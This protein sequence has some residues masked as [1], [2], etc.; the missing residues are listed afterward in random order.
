MKKKT[1]I[2]A[3][4]LILAIAFSGCGNS[5]ETVYEE[6][7]RTDETQSADD[8]A[9]NASGADE[10]KSEEEKSSEEKTGEDS[11]FGGSG[12]EEDAD[13]LRLIN[14]YFDMSK[15]TDGEGYVY[16][17]CF[18]NHILCTPESGSSHPELAKTLK[19]I[20]DDE[21]A[22]FADEISKYERDAFEY[23]E[24]ARAAGADGYYYSYA[25]DVLKRADDKCVSIVRVMKGY[26][27]GAHPDYYYETYNVDPST[28]KDIIMSDVITDQEKLNKIL[29]QKL[30]ADYPDVEY[31]GL[32]DSLAE[33]DI[34]LKE[35]SEDPDGNYHYAY[36]FTLDPD[37]VSFYFSPYGISAYA[38]G[39]QVVK[40]LYD[41]EPSLFK[42]DYSHS[43]GYISYLTEAENKY[44]FGGTAEELK[45]SREE[46]DQNDYFSK[47]NIYKGSKELSLGDMDYYSLKAFTAHTDDD[48]DYLYIIA[49]M[50][51]DYKDFY[52]VDLSKD[53]P[54]EVK[55]DGSL[56]Y[57]YCDYINEKENIYGSVLS[58]DPNDMELGVRCDLLSTYNA[59]G[60]FKVGDDGKLIMKD[61]YLVIPEDVFVLTSKADL[62]ADI[63]DESGKVKEEDVTIPE[64]SK[65]TLY[66]TDAKSIVDAYLEDGRIVRLEISGNNPRKVND[67]FSCDD[68]FDGMIYAG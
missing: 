46:Y 14:T 2:V 12:T 17:Q 68:L 24:E 15:Y 30:V 28:G 3:L 21:E 33:Y 34:K 27:G 20:S 35:G 31:F 47:I 49:N 60:K 37:G 1:V 45:I 18:G 43:G 58:L 29:E 11:L 65:Y 67:Q 38:F 22:F 13:R 54:A 62:K 25:D 9:K 40:I 48:R 23:E 64:G 63:V 39:D 8:T 42:K 26:L 50:D 57:T 36:N 16:F 61:G 44:S 19:R 5:E 59:T 55:L 4:L 6:N 32:E 66:R 52:A 10:E 56:S 53:A 7:V 51:N 41:E